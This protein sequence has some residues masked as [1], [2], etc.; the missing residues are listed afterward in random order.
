MQDFILNSFLINPM[1]NCPFCGIAAG[2][3]P[4]H[5]VYQ[6]NMFIAF[7]DIN[8]A[9]P[10]HLVITPKAHFSS[11]M[12]M[13]PED[14]SQF[15]MIGRVLALALLE[16][17]AEGVNF[18]H[19]MGEAAGQRVP[20][21]MLHV[22]PRYKSDKVHLVWDPQKIDDSKFAEIRERIASLIKISGQTQQPQQ[23]EP[24]PMPEQ[25]QQVQEPDELKV[26]DLPPK[27]GGY[28]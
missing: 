28:W 3:I 1:E 8:P 18:L 25:P 22:I 19:S 6:D 23:S 11:I 4:S 27:T 24:Q 20:H 14:Y 10:G 5:V 16:F 2:K 9:N 26:Y 15:F 12:E 17:G 13:R 7:L 21:T